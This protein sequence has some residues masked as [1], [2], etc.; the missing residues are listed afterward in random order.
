MVRICPASVTV[1]FMVSL[2]ARVKAETLVKPTANFVL[3]QGFAFNLV[4]QV[5][6]STAALPV[7]GCHRAGPRCDLQPPSHKQ[8]ISDDSGGACGC[9]V[10]GHF[11]A[12]GGV[13]VDEDDCCGC[14]VID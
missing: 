11:V 7:V 1:T 4:N 5:S 13:G 9:E 3:T 14:R 10:D 2:P 8:H 12:E 6:V